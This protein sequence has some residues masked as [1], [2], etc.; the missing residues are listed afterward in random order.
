MTVYAD[1]HRLLQVLGNLLQNA[2][3][4]TPEGG[5]I[6]LA[7][8]VLDGHGGGARGAGH[9]DDAVEFSVRD[10]GTGIP[11]DAVPHVFE[12]FFRVSQDARGLGLGL[13]IARSVVVAHGGGIRCESAPDQ[14]ALFVFH[15]PRRARVPTS[16]SVSPAVSREGPA[17]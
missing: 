17:R 8:R 1:H 4:F 15:I 13:A 3:K 14:G 10:T 2:V 5:T 11:E 9:G 12:R 6:A 7:A 16:A